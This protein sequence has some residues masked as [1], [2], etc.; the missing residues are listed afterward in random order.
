MKRLI[1]ILFIVCFASLCLETFVDA[2][3]YRAKQA[4]T[5]FLKIPLP[6]TYDCPTTSIKI[7][8]TK[9]GSLTGNDCYSTIQGSP[10][11]ADRYT[12]SA[13]KGQ[14]IEILLTSDDFDAYLYLLGPNEV[15]L[16]EDDDCRDSLDDCITY[17]PLPSDGKY[18][19]EVTSSDYYDEVGTGNYML[20][21]NPANCL[22]NSVSV[23]DT[24]NGALTRDDCPS[25]QSEWY[26]ADRYTL[27]GKNGQQVDIKLTSPD[28]STELYLFSPDGI[29]LREDFGGSYSWISYTLEE[30]GT[31]VIEVTSGG[32]DDTGI[33]TLNLGDQNNCIFNITPTSQSFSQNAGIGDIDVETNQVCS[34]TATTVETW[35]NIISGNNGT[36]EGMV[37]YLV[38]PNRKRISRTGF[39]IIAGQTFTVQQSGKKPYMH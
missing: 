24:V 16:A 30:N 6:Y 31:Y 17:Y 39:I 13:S 3:T 11:Y 33:Y 32:E 36:G 7:G 21:L 15:I 9:G 29:L 14:Q 1:T 12:F 38:S 22:V 19:I 34:W 27:N 20:T 28:F 26:Y 37:Y 25:P 5:N 8:E 10:Y 35:I 18:I 4:A 23:G 2:D